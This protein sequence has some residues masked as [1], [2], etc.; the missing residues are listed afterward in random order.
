MR[1]CFPSS[2]KARGEFN[3]FVKQMQDGTG[4]GEDKFVKMLQD[5]G[6][7]FADVGEFLKDHIDLV[8]GAVAVSASQVRQ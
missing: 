4:D 6:K 3:K 1:D 2:R 5:I 7:G 8:K